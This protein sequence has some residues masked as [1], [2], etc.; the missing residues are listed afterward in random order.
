MAIT[1]AAVAATATVASTAASM[2]SA[3]KKEKAAG[4]GATMQAP[5]PREALMRRTQYNMLT[6]AGNYDRSARA[7][8]GMI[9]PDL[10]DFAGFD[11]EQDPNAVAN[12]EAAQA[13][14]Q[15]AQQARLDR[16]RELDDL[17]GST[18]AKKKGTKKFEKRRNRARKARIWADREAE[19]AQAEADA[20]AEQLFNPTSIKR[21]PGGLGSEEER[22][23][24]EKLLSR[25][26]GA[27]EGNV[28]EDPYLLR[29]LAEDEAE[30]RAKLGRQF[31]SDYE[32][33]TAGA[34]ATQEFGKRRQE[35][36]ADYARKDITE[37]LPLRQ[38]FE[39]S[40]AEQS[41]NRIRLALAPSGAYSDAATRMANLGKEYQ[42]ATESYQ[43][44]RM[45]QLEADRETAARR[46]EAAGGTMGAL[47]SGLGQLGQG[48][49]AYAW[50]V[51]Q[52]A[53]KTG[54]Q[55]SGWTDPVGKAWDWLKS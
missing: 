34:Y 48:A 51:S 8:M 3:K 40:L 54:Q 44:D 46:Y 6:G 16:Q 49:G 29:K 30:L 2:A 33:S 25:V 32:T 27:L 47:A 41:A 24:S 17:K 12:Y 39:Q 45:G 36:L 37:F 23:V 14:V 42:T 21:R 9:T 52:T 18:S 4:K 11:A 15:R 31:G 22:G 55:P 28:T 7:Q 10:Y 53:P 38:Q 5:G 43:R 26:S 19:T 20:A 1:A 35:L 13:K 50:G